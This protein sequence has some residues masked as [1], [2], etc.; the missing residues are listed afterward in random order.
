MKKRTEA[1]KTVTISCCYGYIKA[2]YRS[3]EKLKLKNHGVQRSTE[4]NN[5]KLN[6]LYFEE[7]QPFIRRSLL[8]RNTRNIRRE[9]KQEPSNPRNLQEL[10]VIPNSTNFLTD[11]FRKYDDWDGEG[12]VLIFSSDKWLDYLEQ[13]PR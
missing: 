4:I 9:A 2:I 3:L 1:E 10:V 7:A 8:A 13:V 12:R 5:W 11:E 6:Q